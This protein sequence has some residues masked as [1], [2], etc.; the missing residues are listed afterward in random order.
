MLPY[1][2][3][4]K[5]FVVQTP[6]LRGQACL[7]QSGDSCAQNVGCWAVV[8]NVCFKCLAF[9]GAFTGNTVEISA[10]DSPVVLKAGPRSKETL[11]S[12]LL[13]C[14][15]VELVDSQ[16]Q[17]NKT[18]QICLIYDVRNVSLENMFL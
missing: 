18:D 5:V 12:S 16:G 4:W 7:L 11:F 17:G 6:A 9:Q 14:I 10:V 3:T 15:P 2:A 1:R 8:G 13:W